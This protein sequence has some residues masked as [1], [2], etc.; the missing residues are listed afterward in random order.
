[1]TKTGPLTEVGNYPPTTP[2]SRFLCKSIGEPL[3]PISVELPKHKN[4]GKREKKNTSS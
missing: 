1:M 3:N 4:W 2:L